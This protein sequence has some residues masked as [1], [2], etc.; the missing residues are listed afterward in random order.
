[1]TKVFISHSSVDKPFARKLVDDL[2]SA[3]LEVWFDREYY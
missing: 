3:G 2:E 1:M